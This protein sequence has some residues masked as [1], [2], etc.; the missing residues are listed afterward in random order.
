MKLH[1]QVL[2]IAGLLTSVSGA[3]AGSLTVINSDKSHTL[4]DAFVEGE[5]LWVLEAELKTI[6]GFELKKEGLCYGSI[7]IPL[8]AKKA[9]WLKQREGKQFFNLTAFA[10]Q[11]KQQYVVD[12]QKTAFSFARFPD[13]ANRDLAIG[14]APNF[15]LKDREGK[16][17]RLS[18]FR[19]KKVLI[20][21]F[22][23]W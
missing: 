12:E 19:G 8:P 20:W 6:N 13:L 22:A 10:R 5:D 21:T 16:T 7:C 18:D 17:V 3:Y 14:K 15:A 1:S 9:K 2:L 4:T 23:S 11:M